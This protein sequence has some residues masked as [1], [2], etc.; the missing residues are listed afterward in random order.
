MENVSVGEI[1]SDAKILDVREDYEWEAGHIDG[2]LH[3]PLDSLPE[4]L[5][6]LD[7][8]QDLAV[9]CRSGGRSARATAWL[10]S[11]GYSAVN[12]TGGMGAWLEAGK[13]MVSDNG[14]DPTVV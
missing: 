2:A 9:I 7:P 13:P 1:S 14:Q 11:H 3:I 5:N 8:D 4:R 6:D 12:V 10:E